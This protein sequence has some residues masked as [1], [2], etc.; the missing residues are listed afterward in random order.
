[1]I[2]RFQSPLTCLEHVHKQRNLGENK[3]AFKEKKRKQVESV[4]SRLRNSGLSTA[5]PSSNIGFKLL[6]KQGYTPGKG[7]GNGIHVRSEP[8]EVDLKRGR[9]GLGIDAV[10]REKAKML[11]EKEK[12]KIEEFQMNSLVIEKEFHEMR[13]VKWESKKIARDVAKAKSA[14]RDLADKDE[15]ERLNENET[16]GIEG[17]I[18]SDLLEED[19]LVECEEKL[20]KRI[21]PFTYEIEEENLKEEKEVQVEEPTMEVCFNLCQL[22]LFLPK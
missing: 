6:Q 7:L 13:K 12:K 17:L 22:F 10:L 21:K 19:I 5:I 2:A 18:E 3:K 20:H 9:G 15:K 4:E 14:L 1:M 16:K 8:I 11:E